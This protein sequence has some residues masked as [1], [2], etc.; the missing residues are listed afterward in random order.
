MFTAAFG[1]VTAAHP[2]LV[3]RVA[4]IFFKI[5]TYPAGASVEAPCLIS[6][7]SSSQKIYLI[8]ACLLYGNTLRGLY[9]TASILTIRK[10]LWYLRWRWGPSLERGSLDCVWVIILCPNVSSM[11][12]GYN[13][14]IE[15]FKLL[16]PL[17]THRPIHWSTDF[18]M[19]PKCLRCRKTWWNRHVIWGDL[20]KSR[21]WCQSG[22]AGLSGKMIY[23]R[24]LIRLKLWYIN[25]SNYITPVIY[26]TR[27]RSPF[28]GL[29]HGLLTAPPKTRRLRHSWTPGKS[30]FASTL[31]PLP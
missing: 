3:A 17:K 19:Y 2:A 14:S 7:T 29:Q 21:A 25:Q 4:V 23:H 10:N 1:L 5:Y 12:N 20:G 24:C 16:H 15:P 8:S 9:S 31:P 18:L 22:L 26:H 6:W 28:F 30:R 11:Y 13:S 27:Y